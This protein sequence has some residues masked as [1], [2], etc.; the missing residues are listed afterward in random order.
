M[1]SAA[2]IIQ[3]RELLGD[4][5]IV[6]LASVAPSGELHSRPLTLAEIDDD[7]MLVFLVDSAASWVLGLAPNELVNASIVNKSDATWV[8]VSGTATIDADRA[9]IHRL[10]SKPAEA[11]FPDGVDSPNIQVLRLRPSS[12]EY[13][14]APAGRVARLVSMAG[15][16]VGATKTSVG[17][18]GTIDMH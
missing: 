11:F 1:T 18:S 9:S 17:D 13:W 16:I 6:M 14:D 8:S 7:G 15:A 2:A 3:L 5:R 4:E 12:A 10:W